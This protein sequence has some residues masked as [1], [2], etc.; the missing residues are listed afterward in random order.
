MDPLETVAGRAEDG[1]RGSAEEAL[2]EVPAPGRFAG[3]GAERRRKSRSMARI[4]QA[5]V[6]TS[7]MGGSESATKTA[8]RQAETID[9]IRCAIIARDPY[10][11]DR[12]DHA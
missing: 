3:S 4:R 6:C 7:R 2:G 11:I 9:H 1:V 5:I 12:P 8:V 10:D